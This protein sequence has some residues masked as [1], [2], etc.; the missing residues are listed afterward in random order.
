MTSL[1]ALRDG[2]ERP[3]HLTDL[4]RH[5]VP[6][7]VDCLDPDL[8]ATL[9]SLGWARTRDESIEPLVRIDSWHGLH[10]AHDPDRP[11]RIERETVVGVN[12]T[13]RS[14]AALTPRHHVRRALDLATGPGGLALLLARHADQVIA[15]DLSERACSFATANARL[16]E[17]PVDVRMGDL[18][19]PV[20]GEAPFDI[21]SANLPFVVS[22]E[23]VYTFRDG[24]RD[25][26]HISRDAVAGAAARLAPGGTAVLMCN[27]LVTQASAPGEVPMAW[28][29]E[30]T[31]SVVVL[32]HSVESPAEYAARWNQ[33]VLTRDP[34]AYAEAVERWTE[35]FE[36]WGIDG[37]ANGT[38]VVH[39]PSDGATTF[40]RE[41]EMSHAPAGDGG[42]QVTRIISNNGWLA[43]HPSIEELLAAVPVLVAPHRLDQTMRFDGS[44]QAGAAVLRLDDTAGVAGKVEPLATHV[45]LRADGHRRL[46]QLVDDAADAT[47]ID[48]AE[49]GRATTPSVQALLE[50]GCL[51]LAESP[52][53]G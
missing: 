35:A 51:A 46:D 9:E 29:P 25:R 44:W 5:E 38:I 21:I 11:E 8:V 24:G 52:A 50:A 6:V 53:P 37:I 20:S 2:L 43:R 41:L 42:K 16:N 36:S 4:L 10:L 12:N 49:L 32:H 22:P 26:D 31:H 15:T 27:W 45:L 19:D 30:P 48:R 17:L 7:P 34:S 18:Y 39:R 47:G 14:L 13:T 40:R 3:G 28:V 33:F 1:R 23:T